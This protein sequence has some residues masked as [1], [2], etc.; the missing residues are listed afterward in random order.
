MERTPALI[1]FDCD[2]VLVDSEPLSCAILAQALRQQGLDADA[3]YVKHHFLGRSL[4]AVRTHAQEHGV[5]LADDFESRL[6]AELL[7]RFADELKPMPGVA[8]LLQTLDVPTCVA[9]SSHLARVRLSL[10]VTGLA[11]YFDEHVYTAEMVERGKPAPDLFL[12]AAQRM[13]VPPADCLVLEDS[14]SGVQAALAA[15]MTAWGFTGGSHHGTDRDAIQRLHDAGAKRVLDDM[16]A[17]GR[18]IGMTAPA[19]HRSD[20]SARDGR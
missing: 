4:G 3:E 12:F 14:P 13:Q 5:A 17:V 1:I 10:E 15:G 16:A 6:N 2:G 9:S 11:R 7:A 20:A 8:T 18:A 19:A